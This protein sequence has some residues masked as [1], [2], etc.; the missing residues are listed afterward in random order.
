M[1]LDNNKLK[2]CLFQINRSGIN[3]RA[4]EL[5]LDSVS[6]T[7]KLMLR[8]YLED[9]VTGMPVWDSERQVPEKIIA[10]VKEILQEYQVQ[11]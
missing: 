1:A 3:S 4:G 2:R 6:N 8:K 9:N 5:L 10:A 7:G 11:I